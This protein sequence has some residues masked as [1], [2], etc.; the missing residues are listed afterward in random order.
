MILI[1]I[2]LGPAVVIMVCNLLR[3]IYLHLL[4]MDL[5]YNA[6]SDIRATLKVC[7]C[8]DSRLIPICDI[9]GHRSLHTGLARKNQSW[10]GN[11]KITAQPAAAGS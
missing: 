8:F 3:I 5:E 11:E 4:R 2:R 7:C 10:I 6:R 1:I 9:V